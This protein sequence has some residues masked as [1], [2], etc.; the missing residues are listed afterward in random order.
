M[1]RKRCREACGQIRLP[2]CAVLLLASAAAACSSE[3]GGV[4]GQ[5]EPLSSST[6]AL[7]TA[8]TVDGGACA[9]N[10]R[11]VSST[12]ALLTAPKVILVFWGS[13]WKTTA[14]AAEKTQYDATWSFLASAPAFYNRL[15]EYGIGL[16]S[17]GGSVIA[18]TG[19]ASP[20]SLTDTRINSELDAEI[21]AGTLPANGPQ[22]IYSILLPPN[23]TSQH[24]VS[25]NA[26]AHHSLTS[27]NGSN[28][29]YSTTEYNSDHRTSNTFTSHEIGE[30]ETDPDFQGFIDSVSQLEI[31]DVCEGLNESIGNQAVQQMWSQQACA[32]VGRRGRNMIDV[33]A[34]WLS[35][36]VATGTGTGLTSTQ[37][38]V[39]LGAGQGT[40]L[41]THVSSSDFN[42]FATTPGA[43]PSS[44]GTSTAMGRATSSPPAFR[45]GAG[46]ASR[47]RTATGR[48]PRRPASRRLLARLPRRQACKWWPRT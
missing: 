2:T 10:F 43:S 24:D 21:T 36:L 13:Y 33:N 30:T 48:L 35:D 31:G 28:V 26:G 23:V 29:Y 6:A 12:G 16:G 27:L 25:A 22:N 41:A 38:A 7:A 20:S 47:S 8:A 17:F 3:T 5:G 11:R 45:R 40:F 4:G 34:D 19:V 39:A 46:C 1:D 18:N 37:V 44:R 15:R 9:H 32:C 14:G 42:A